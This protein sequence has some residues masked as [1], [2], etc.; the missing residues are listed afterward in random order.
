MRF[1]LSHSWKFKFSQIFDLPHWGKFWQGSLRSLL[2]LQSSPPFWASWI[3][4]LVPVRYPRSVFVWQDTEHLDQE[5]SDHWQST[6]II[7]YFLFLSIGF[8]LN[9]YLFSLPENDKKVMFFFCYLVGLE[10][11]NRPHLTDQHSQNS[12]HISYFVECN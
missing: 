2:P 4:Y 7:R 10:L 11:D 9:I 5:I 1:E 6:T 8:Y 12:H 3:T